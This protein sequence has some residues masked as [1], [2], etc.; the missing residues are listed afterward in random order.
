MHRSLA[1]LTV[2]AIAASGCV[3]KRKY[4]EMVQ[5]RNMYAA[6]GESLTL[7]T[8]VLADVAATFAE[9]LALREMEIE[10]LQDTQRQIEEE[11]QNF[12]IAGVIKISLM[13]DGLHLVLAEDVLFPAGSAEL[14]NHGRTLLANLV[15]ELQGFPYQIAVLGYTDRLPIGSELTARYPSNWELAA[16]RASS[17]VRLLEGAGIASEQLVVVS[18]G[19]NRPF[20]GNDTAEG[21]ALNRRIEI[22][23]RP[24]TPE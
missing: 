14:A 24:V 21:R 11:L 19:S 6:Q 23:L 22:R 4:D 12:I 17:V 16:A 8:E 1:L 9:E 5:Q 18:F 3:S 7:E 10:M 13:R 20:A 2:L 15:D